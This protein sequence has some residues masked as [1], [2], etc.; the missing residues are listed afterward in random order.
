[1]IEFRTVYERTRP[2]QF[3]HRVSDIQHCFHR[4]RLNKLIDNENTIR[5]LN[6]FNNERQIIWNQRNIP[7]RFRIVF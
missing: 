7:G 2:V 3:Q 6:I 5:S 1:M 4:F